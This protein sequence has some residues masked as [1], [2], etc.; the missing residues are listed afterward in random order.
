MLAEIK[1]KTVAGSTAT[2]SMCDGKMVSGADSPLNYLDALFPLNLS[3]GSRLSRWYQLAPACAD[4]GFIL[5]QKRDKRKMGTKYPRQS[6]A[7][8]EVHSCFS[9]L[10]SAQVAKRPFAHIPIMHLNQGAY[11]RPTICLQFI[12]SPTGI[13]KYTM[14]CGKFCQ[15]F[16]QVLF[17]Q[18]T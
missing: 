1:S 8:R 6:V 17:F 4:I 5:L 10:Q 15:F 11:P 9:F 18:D 7:L 14:H 13:I 3:Q 16:F 12:I 2:P